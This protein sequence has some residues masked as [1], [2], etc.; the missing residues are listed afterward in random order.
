MYIMFVFD[1][2]LLAVLSLTRHLVPIRD[3]NDFSVS[4]RGRESSGYSYLYQTF[5]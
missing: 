3:S 2:A 5:M 1:K 4:D